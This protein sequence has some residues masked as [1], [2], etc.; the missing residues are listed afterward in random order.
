MGVAL[1]QYPQIFLPTS[2]HRHISFHEY[3]SAE[4]HTSSRD[5]TWSPQS[6]VPPL[7]LHP[8]ASPRRHMECLAHRLFQNHGAST[9]P[10]E[11]QQILGNHG[12][13]NVT[14]CAKVTADVVRGRVCPRR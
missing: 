8:H 14:S 3:A 10:S 11:A 2:R 1:R 5:T 13:S 4:V 12:T 6:L 7:A 9:K